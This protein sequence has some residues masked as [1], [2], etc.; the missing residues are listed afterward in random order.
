M[1]SMTPLLV[2]LLVPALARGQVGFTPPPLVPVPGPEEVSPDG[3]PQAPPVEGTP[4]TPYLPFGQTAPKTPPGPEIGLMVSESLF[5]MLTAA[6]I[7]ILPFFLFGFSGGGGF[8][9]ND[10]V[11]GTV[12]AALLFGAAPLAIAQTQVGLANGSR[13][14]QSETWPT[15]LAGLAAEAA[16]LALTYATGGAI[17]KN[18][19]T[20]T[21]ANG[22]TPSGCG[23]D[24]LLLV[25]S[26]A[27]VPLIQMAVLN[28]TKQPRVRA[29]A[30]R[31]AR[32]GELS[33][34]LP[35]PS[36][37]LGQTRAGLAVGLNL[38]IVDL[39]F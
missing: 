31:D 28:L 24:V 26:V 16:V 11:A 1:K 29:V 4:A 2:L 23:N 3:P 36:P 9:S 19:N 34:G 27:V 6:G 14:Y 32:T 22:A 37:T 12:V 30:N 10:P 15:A 39:R 21:G 18:T 8:L 7:I 38:P 35:A 13:Q 17:V 5:G 20:C 33:F 25:G